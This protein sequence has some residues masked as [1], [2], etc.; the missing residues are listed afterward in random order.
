MNSVRILLLEDDAS[1]GEVLKLRL[2]NEGYVVEWAKNL[3]KAR[4]FLVSFNPQLAILDV[5]LPDGSGFDFAKEV[6]GAEF[7]FLTAQSDAESRLTGYTLGAAEFIPKPFHLQE[8][9]LRVKHVLREHA[10]TGAER[11]SLEKLSLPHCEI[12]FVSLSVKKADGSVEYPSVTDMKL[13]RCLLESSPQPVSRDELMNKI[14][15]E[16]KN[17]SLRSVDNAIV[18]LRTLLGE[19]QENYIRSVRGIG[20]Q[21]LQDNAKKEET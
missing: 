21:W 4:E 19:G 12:D 6:K 13:L 15:G 18:R 2:Q 17:P 9:L 11:L 3:E 5:G 8:L 7:I 20:Y 16:E 10:D 14:W 1:L